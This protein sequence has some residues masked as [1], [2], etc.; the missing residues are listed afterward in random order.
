MENVICNLCGA[1]A[2]EPF[3][4]VADLM[5]ERFDVQATLVRCTH[6]GLVYQNPRPTLAEIGQHYPPE[7]ELYTDLVAKRPDGLLS[8]AIDYGMRKRCRFVT[9]HK[10]AGRLLDV[11]C[12]TGAFLLAMQRQGSWQVQGVELNEPVARAAREQHQLDIFAGTLE[13]AA[14]PTAYFD[15]VTLWDVLEHLHEPVLA[16]REIERILK[17]DGILVIR[18]PN[19]A[20]WDAA[21]FKTNWIGFDAPRHLYVFTPT[22]LTAALQAAHLAVVDHSCGIGGYVTFVMSI[23]CWMNAHHWAPQVK[24]FISKLLYHPLLR[25]VSVPLFYLP[26]LALRGPSLVTTARKVNAPC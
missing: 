14:F 12:A 16:L 8:Q 7:Y 1:D 22:T 4:I 18:V 19:L 2:T 5:Q 17:P 15:A 25:L 9:R 10:T 11:G 21:L 20:S 13:Q 26:T 3:V 6:C 23:R 24:A